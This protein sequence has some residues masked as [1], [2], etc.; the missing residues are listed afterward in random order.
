MDFKGSKGLD[1][2]SDFDVSAYA[3]QTTPGH[4][5]LVKQQT[6][7]SRL[8][9]AL[10]THPAEDYKTWTNFGLA[11]K[12]ESPDLFW[13]WAAWSKTSKRPKDADCDLKSVWDNDLKPDGRITIGSIF[14]DGK[15]PDKAKYDDYD[16]TE[17]ITA[18]YSFDFLI[19]G[20]VVEQQSCL[21]AGPQKSLKTTLGLNAALCLATGQPFLGR[22][23]KRKRVRFMSG[24][25]GLGTLQETAKRMNIRPEKGFFRLSTTLLRLDQSLV[26]FEE[27]VEGT[28][29]LIVDPAYMCMNGTDAG[30]MFQMGQ[31]LGN[32]SDLCVRHGITP[33]L[34]H[35]VTKEAGR[36]NK[37]IELPDMAWSGFAEFARQWLLVSRRSNYVDGTGEHQLYFRA[38]GSA[39]HSQLLNLD[40]SEG[41]YPNRHWQCEVVSHG[42]I[43]AK[44]VED[45]YEHDKEAVKA[46]LLTESPQTKTNIGKGIRGDRRKTTIDRMINEGFLVPEGRKFKLGES[47]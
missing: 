17:F 27:F 23:C 39:G 6:N 26:D 14:H 46:V 36:K 1:V 3:A 8:V 44:T 16:F 2:T 43:A 30:N 38:G 33:I 5:A 21:F 12:H 31:Q 10:F 32:I 41:T 35:H 29:V 34:L 24:E 42:E 25:S 22:E 13:L 47:N 9:P 18:D 15:E 28:E 20:L 40:I 4:P 45:R 37:P 7:L 19:E 11:L